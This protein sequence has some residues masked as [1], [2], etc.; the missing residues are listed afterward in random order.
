MLFPDVGSYPPPNNDMPDNV[1]GIYREA[2]TIANK[3]PRAAAAILRVALQKLCKELKCPSDK[4]YE[5]ISD[6]LE[7]EKVPS[8]V[9]DAMEVIRLVGNDAAHPDRFGIDVDRN[10]EAV[11]SLFEFINLIVDEMI[12]RPKRK[13]G[14]LDKMLAKYP[15]SKKIK[16]RKGKK[17]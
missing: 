6:L 17:P 3:S 4:L 8:I 1:K 5:Q 16:L 9:I 13:R 7:D 10:L 11:H 12:S 15:A 2:A 14:R